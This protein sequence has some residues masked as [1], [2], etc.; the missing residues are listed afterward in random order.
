MKCLLLSIFLFPIFFSQAEIKTLDR[1]RVQTGILS[2]KI[3]IKTEPK[4]TKKSPTKVSGK[5]ASKKSKKILT[6][7]EIS[8]STAFII[9]GIGNSMT[10]GSGFFITKSLLVT[11]SHVVEN[12]VIKHNIKIVSIETQQGIKDIGFVF[13]EDRDNDLAIIKTIKKTH[14]PLKLG[15]YNKVKMGD[16]IFVLGSPQGL[17]GTLSKG[18]VSA[19][20][21]GTGFQMLQLTAP[22]SQGSSGSPVLSKDLKVIGIV[23]A[24]LES[25]QNINFAVPVTYLKKLIK[26]NEKALIKLSKLNLEKVLKDNKVIIPV[27]S[28]KFQELRTDL[29]KGLYYYD[30]KDYKQAVYWL[31]KAARQEQADAQLILGGMYYKGEGVSKDYKQAVYWYKK[32]A[33]QGHVDAQVVLGIMHYYGEGGVSKDHKQ[34]VYWYKKAAGQGQA[35]AQLILGRMYYNGEGVSKDYKQAVYW[36]KK[37]AGQ[38][39]VDAQVVLGM[40]HYYGEGGVS[41]DHKQAVYWYKKAAGQGQADAQAFLGGMYYSGIGVPQNFIYAYSWLNLAAAKGNNMAIK[42]RDKIL[43]NMSSNQIALAQQLSTQIAQ[44]IAQREMAKRQIASE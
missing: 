20:R 33:G 39:H 5:T 32:A 25:G 44:E 4:R 10:T 28:K 42:L 40:M 19:K 31:K 11:N 24:I 22:I 6:L 14:K 17:I 1:E 12:A 43:I 2:A 34:A 38:G 37:A 29:D 15:K 16:E 41:K 7:E 26:T 8:K 13:V 27:E 18:I 35:D 9:S 21:K 23:V 3:D 36:Y 30:K